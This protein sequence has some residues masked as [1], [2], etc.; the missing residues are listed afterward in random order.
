MYYPPKPKN[1]AAGVVTSGTGETHRSKSVVP[2]LGV[3]NLPGVICDF[4]RGDV[5]PKPQCSILRAIVGNK[6]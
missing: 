2:K 4:S 5:E 6:T 1:L 3:N